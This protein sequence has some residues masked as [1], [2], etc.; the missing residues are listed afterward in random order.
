MELALISPEAEGP[1]ERRVLKTLFSA[2]LVRLHVRRPG[3][4]A[5][6]MRRWVMAAPATWRR[7]LILHGHPD[8]AAE[9]ELAGTHYP[10]KG[11]PVSPAPSPSP[12]RACHSLEELDQAL[13]RY[14]AVLLSPIFAS[15]SKPDYGPGESL[16]LETITAR[17]TRRTREE[18]RTRVFALGGVD[19]GKLAACARAG[20]D[21][22]A[23]LGAVWQAIDPLSA[24]TH[25]RQEAERHAA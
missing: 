2:G 10:A 18:R 22:V 13:G 20:F 23:V 21:G 19:S 25:L 16:S 8:L 1:H 6:K 14:D 17:L 3:W 11:A 4:D 5:F 24:F 12:S 15:I 7:H 9:Y